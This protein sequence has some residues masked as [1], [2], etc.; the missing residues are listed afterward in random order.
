MTPNALVLLGLSVL[1]VARTMPQ[2]D[3]SVRFHRRQI[4]MIGIVTGAPGNQR[5]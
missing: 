5:P 2:I 4:F 3:I 1:L